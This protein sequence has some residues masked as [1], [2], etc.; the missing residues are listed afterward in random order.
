M[1]S[2]LA[3]AFMFG[4]PAL[5]A[6]EAAASYLSVSRAQLLEQLS[7][8]KSLAQVAAAHGKSVAGLK[9]AIT[10]AITRAA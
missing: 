1:A 6:L 10:A 3:R 4:G 2:A 8:G 9:D 7:A 5:G